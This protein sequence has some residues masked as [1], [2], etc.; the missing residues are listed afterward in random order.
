MQSKLSRLSKKRLHNFHTESGNE[1]HT[2][3]RFLDA[4]LNYSCKIYNDDRS[5]TLNYSTM[6]NFNI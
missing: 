1:L 2:L 3:I 5:L 4:Y 6:K